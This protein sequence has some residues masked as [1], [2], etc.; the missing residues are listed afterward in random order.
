MSNKNGIGSHQS[1]DSDSTQWL[2]PPYILDELGSFDLD[3]CAPIDR[4]WSMADTHFTE[5][6]D[7][8]SNEWF[9]RVWC[10][11]PYGNE[12]GTWLHRLANHGNGMALI[13]ARTETNMFFD[14]IW[15]E[16]DG[17]LFIEGRLYFYNPDGSISNNNSGA[18]SALVAY[19]E[20]NIS[21]LASSN[22]P[23]SLVRNWDILRRQKKSW[24]KIDP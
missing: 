12:T 4:P 20:S 2:T 23:G 13:F 16:A 11:P 21:D 15:E 19:G 24:S 17:I 1:A 18:P 10:N 5:T 22:I 14:Q 3:P 9:G 8:L 7:G 6:D